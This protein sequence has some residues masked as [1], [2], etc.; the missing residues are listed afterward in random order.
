MTTQPVGRRR[1]GPVVIG[2]DGSPAAEDALAQAAS[3]LRV[4][5]VL[6]VVVWEAG[7]AFEAA[8]WAGITLDTPVPVVDLRTAAD[9][10]R[11]TY[12]AAERAAQRGVAA[13]RSLGLDADPLVVAGDRTVADTLVRVSRERDAPALVIGARHHG[14]LIEALRG[15]TERGRPP[16]RALPGPRRPPGGR[17]RPV[18]PRPLISGETAPCSCTPPR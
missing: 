11:A 17:R 7:R 18:T 5:S 16:L 2:Y 6:L 15:S 10:D 12:V 3:V 9:L 8:E 4:D 13:A 1:T 14:T